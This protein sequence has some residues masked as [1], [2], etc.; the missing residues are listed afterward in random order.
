[1]G[2]TLHSPEGV[3]YRF[4]PGALCLEFVPTGGPGPYVR[5]ETLHH[6]A[7]LAV[8]AAQSRLTPTPEI[9]VT[10]DEVVEARRLRDAV[11][12]M[13]AARAHDR[14]LDPADLAIVNAAAA[15]PPLVPQVDG[16]AERRWLRPATGTQLLSTVARDAIDLFS[17]PYA[18]RIRECATDDCYLLFVDT[19]RPGRRRWCS[20][21]RCGNRHKV[22]ALRARQAPL[23]QQPTA[24]PEDLTMQQ[25]TPHDPLRDRQRAS[26]QRA[27]AATAARQTAVPERPTGLTRDAGWEIGVSKTLPHP[28][29]VVWDFI[30][31]SEGISIWLGPGA[32]LH[33]AKGERYEADDGTSGEVRG[34]RP[35]DR[36]RLTHRLPGSTR[37]TTIQVAV[38]R[39][40]SE[41]KAVLRFHQERLADA[42]ERARRREH[43]KQVMADV[44]DA[45]G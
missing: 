25:D 10:P 34:Y 20:M 8:W 13:A 23:D 26:R 5:Y 24:S 38:A 42:E 7:D 1:M 37:D 40:G 28:P 44:A 45:L 18:D 19:S 22:R 4:D 39:A 43:W 36:I 33:G 15:R 41:E 14:P 17:G 29:S 16:P 12:R 31:G 27:S 35:G 2:L 21:Q 9:E 30:S 6:P 11:L 3:A 32:E